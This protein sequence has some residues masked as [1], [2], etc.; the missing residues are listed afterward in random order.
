MKWLTSTVT[1]FLMDV[2]MGTSPNFSKGWCPKVNKIEMCF[3]DSSFSFLSFHKEE[4]SP[5]CAPDTDL[6]KR[7]SLS[8]NELSDGWVD[9]TPYGQVPPYAQG[10]V[11]RHYHSSPSKR[12][13]GRKKGTESFFGSKACLPGNPPFT[14]LLH[15]YIIFPLIHII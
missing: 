12:L 10:G 6:S 5:A 4:V 11:W 15:V 2:S 3:I 8:A 14:C 1:H 7:L 9:R 13:I